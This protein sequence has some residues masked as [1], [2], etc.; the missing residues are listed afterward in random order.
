VGFECVEAN[1]A[2][3]AVGFTQAIGK[4]GN[5]AGFESGFKFVGKHALPSDFAWH[6]ILL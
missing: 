4:V 3:G 2:L 1:G 5:G 6:N